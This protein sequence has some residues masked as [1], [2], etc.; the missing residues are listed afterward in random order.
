MAALISS[1][2]LAVLIALAPAD[3]KLWAAGMVAAVARIA[4]LALQLLTTPATFKSARGAA[5][6][7]LRLTTTLAINTM[8]LLPQPMFST[9][10]GGALSGGDAGKVAVLRVGR[11][12]WRS[13]TGLDALT[14]VLTFLL[15]YFA[16]KTMPKN[17]GEAARFAVAAIGV[18]ATCGHAR[19]YA[20][21]EGAMAVSTIGATVAACLAAALAF[22]CRS[23][24]FVTLPKSW[25]H[26]RASLSISTG[27]A[28]ALLAAAL[29]RV[30]E[31]YLYTGT[32]ERLCGIDVSAALALVPTALMLSRHEVALLHHPAIP[33][34]SGWALIGADLLM[35]NPAQSPAVGVIGALAYGAILVANGITIL[36]GYY[37]T[38][39]TWGMLHLATYAGSD[40]APGKHEVALFGSGW[41]TLQL[42]HAKG[43]KTGSAAL[44][45]SRECIPRRIRILLDKL[46]LKGKPLDLSQ[47]ANLMCA[48]AVVVHLSIARP[49]QGKL[50]PFVGASSFWYHPYVLL[51]TPLL[52]LNLGKHAWAAVWKGKAVVPCGLVGL[53]ELLLRKALAR[54]SAVGAKLALDSFGQR[55]PAVSGL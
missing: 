45:F 35:S 49:L 40:A 14:G 22:M 3:G 53:P 8:A 12:L 51:G 27:I 38:A 5:V 1:D 21:I 15:A 16:C 41:G 19:S 34:P 32:L 28:S 33:T 9:V 42:V 36:P 43:L 30:V 26:L 6:A 24:W 39:L 31:T 18:L 54:L 7:C 4:F 13:S 23:L 17:A 37:L 11:V 10:L 44:A 46:F 50:L 29:W 52:L 55:P 48:L 20:H 25:Q 2:F 47:A